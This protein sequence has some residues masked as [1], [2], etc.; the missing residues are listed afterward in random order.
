M[1]KKK[2]GRGFLNRTRRPEQEPVAATNY[3]QVVGG[4][5][6][7]QPATRTNKVSV[8][9]TPS[10]RLLSINGELAYGI[11][12]LYELRERTIKL[13]DRLAGKDDETGNTL[14]QPPAS[15]PNGDANAL[16]YSASEITVLVNNLATEFA[17][18]EAL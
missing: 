15:P 9:P 11:K 18:L 10:T 3:H 12:V 8:A 14:P 2:T 13:G 7:N 1:R 5:G 6:Q 17:R 16:E 4:T